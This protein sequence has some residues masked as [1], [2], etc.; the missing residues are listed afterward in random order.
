[1]SLIQLSDNW[2]TVFVNSENGTTKVMDRA[3]GQELFCLSEPLLMNPVIDGKTSDLKLIGTKKLDNEIRL[4]FSEKR[5]SEFTL[6][7]KAEKEFIDI[8]SEFSLVSRGELDRLN[9]FPVGTVVNMY[10]LVNF[11]NRHHTPETY[12]ELLLGGKGCRTTTYSSDWQFAPHPALFILRKSGSG[13]FVGKVDLAK[14]FGMYIEVA[15]YRVKA[16][17]L[18]FGNFE[19]GLLLKKGE[20]FVSP[21]MRLFLRHNKSVGD[22]LGEFSRMLIEEGVIADPAKKERCKWWEE[23][24]YCS[25]GDQGARADVRIPEDLKEQSNPWEPAPKVLDA[26]MV[27][28]AVNV[29]KREKLAIRTILLDEGWEITRGQWEPDRDRFPELRRLVDELHAEGFKVVVWWNWA[30]IY[31]EA[32]VEEQHLMADG[33]RNRHGKLIRDYSKRSTQVYLK[34]LFYKLFSSDPG[35]YDLDGVKTDFQADKVH[36]DMP[37]EN[38]EWRGEENYFYHIYKLFYSEMKKLKSDAVHIGCAGNYYLARFIDIN[39]TYDV[40]SSNFLEHENRA[41]MLKQTCP[42]C[43]VAY[44]LHSFVEN[45]DEYFESAERNNC[46]VQIGKVLYMQKNYFSDNVDADNEYYKILRKYL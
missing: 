1:M 17:Y 2:V 31:D 33:K 43:P 15:D 35:C 22:I 20:K 29:I 25:W 36:A 42:G 32:E 19:N 3:T 45:L 39:R 24:L 8:Y 28:K 10:N 27:R 37:V 13:L 30:E 6:I 44:D 41:K 34:S 46:S 18:D 5:F 40:A 16:W 4:S 11:R 26:D 14:D 21:R 7:L 12:P 9:I 23:P 38:P